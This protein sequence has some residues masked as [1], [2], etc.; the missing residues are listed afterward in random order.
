MVAISPSLLCALRMVVFVAMMEKVIVLPG[1]EWG[2][3]GRDSEIVLT[4]R[5]TR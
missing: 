4:A 3:Q 1:L 5:G 2:E